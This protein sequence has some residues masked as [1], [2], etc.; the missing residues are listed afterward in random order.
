[1]STGEGFRSWHL[2]A[3][4]LVYR[5]YK[6]WLNHTSSVPRAR[7]LC[8][9]LQC[10]AVIRR[11]PVQSRVGTLTLPPPRLGFL[12]CC[13][14]IELVKWVYACSSL[15]AP[16]RLHHP[17]EQKHAVAWK[18]VYKRGPSCIAAKSFCC[19]FRHATRPPST[20]RVW[21]VSCSTFRQLGASSSYA[22][23]HVFLR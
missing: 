5:C 18:S 10:K 11:S 23:T 16:V 9:G 22:I 6:I 21:R 7:R 4:T 15:R 19:R 13:R 12:F 2:R 17:C 20:R 8:D 14:R 3:Q 1:M